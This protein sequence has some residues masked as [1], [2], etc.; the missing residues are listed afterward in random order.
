MITQLKIMDDNF[1][2]FLKIKMFTIL[3]I[4]ALTCLCISISSQWICKEKDLKG[5]IYFYSCLIMPVMTTSII[6][7]LICS[8]MR[9]LFTKYYL[10]TKL[11]IQKECIRLI[12]MIMSLGYIVPTIFIQ[13]MNKEYACIINSISNIMF[14]I[15]FVLLSIAFVIKS[16]HST[17]DPQ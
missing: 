9:D 3:R 6:L 14:I 2:K 4:V 10:D 11:D 12:A 1:L 13:Y 5:S 15:F 8:D 16:R 7:R 17:I